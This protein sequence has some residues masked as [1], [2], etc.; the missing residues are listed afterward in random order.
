MIKIILLH[1]IVLYLFDLI[2]CKRCICRHQIVTF[3]RGNKRS[4]YSNQ[5]IIH[6][7]GITKCCCACRHYSRYLNRLYK[8][9]SV[10]N[11]E[12]EQEDEQEERP[13]RTRRKGRLRRVRG[14]GRPKKVRGRGRGRGIFK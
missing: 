13:R 7:S 8:F 5:I 4:N 11:E 2:T 10:N 12:T 1:G 3:G 14:S 6:I 9:F